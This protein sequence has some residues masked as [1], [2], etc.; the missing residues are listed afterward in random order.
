MASSN[1][2]KCGRKFTR[3]ARRSEHHV[4]PR[5]FFGNTSTKLV[6]CRRCHDRIERLIPFQEQPSWFYMYIADR[7]MEGI[8]DDPE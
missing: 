3:N 6:L 8:F 5:R 2:P 4:Y 1:C 7:F